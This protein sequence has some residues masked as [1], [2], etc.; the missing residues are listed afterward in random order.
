VIRLRRTGP[1]GGSD[2]PRRRLEDGW[3]LI[4]L[5]LASTLFLIVVAVSLQ[6]V[7]V[8]QS[9]FRFQPAAADVQQRL[10]VAI[11]GMSHDLQQAGAG[12]VVGA[13]A[14]P[15]FQVLPP[16]RLGRRGLREPDGEFEARSDRVTVLW[17]PS[18]AH[19]TTLVADMASPGDALVIDPA[20]A[21]CP[22]DGACGF[23]PGTRAL[24]L[25]P[26]AAGLGYDVFTVTGVGAGVLIHGPPNRT[27]SR[28]YDR[29][30]SWVTE[31]VQHSY[32]Y[33]A[34]SSRLMRSDGWMSDLPLVDD[35]IGF[36]MTVRAAP[37][38][39]S[40]QPPRPGESTCL[41]RA[42]PPVEPLLADLGGSALRDLSAAQLADG[43]VCGLAPNRFDGDLL[44][45]RSVRV[46]IGLRAASEG[47]DV[48]D[49]GQSTMRPYRAPT[50]VTFEV[51]LRNAPTGRPVGSTASGL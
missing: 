25:D 34:S 6:L 35:V 37:D 24:V 47:T 48:A 19:Q 15:L 2:V 23:S 17:A 7:A 51:S 16:V 38:P 33:D 36:E 12:L 10:R 29:D 42:G 45:V 9:V 14:G 31:V 13:E 18:G 28:A 50:W 11:E 30:V 21:G 1:R 44:R 46:R 8:G 22:A 32:Y 20:S 49:V 4:E 40:V 41:F 26:R 43:P 27:L 39:W 5:L 3:T